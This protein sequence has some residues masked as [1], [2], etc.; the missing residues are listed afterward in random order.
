LAARAGRVQAREKEIFHLLDTQKKLLHNLVSLL[1]AQCSA[2]QAQGGERIPQ[3][4]V[5]L[6]ASTQ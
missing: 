2:S 1:L 5:E 4:A 3:A 6:A